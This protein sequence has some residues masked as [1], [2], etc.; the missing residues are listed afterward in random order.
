[1]NLDT[2]NLKQSFNGIAF[3][4]ITFKTIQNCTLWIKMSDI[5]KQLD[6]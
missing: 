3:N 1:M 5:I 6:S 4:G 2:I